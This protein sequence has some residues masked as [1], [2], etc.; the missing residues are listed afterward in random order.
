ML[1][2]KIG[3]WLFSKQPFKSLLMVFSTGRYNKREWIASQELNKGHVWK[4]ASR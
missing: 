1:V 2:H 3:E 4:L